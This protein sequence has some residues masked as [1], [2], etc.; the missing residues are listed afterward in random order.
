M[1]NQGDVQHSLKCL[2][3]PRS[4]AILHIHQLVLGQALVSQSIM[5]YRGKREEFPFCAYLLLSLGGA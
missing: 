4:F 2:P 1:G 5:F 3:K